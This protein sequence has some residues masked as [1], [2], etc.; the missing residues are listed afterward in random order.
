MID[1]L[2]Q[3]DGACEGSF[4]SAYFR[5]DENGDILNVYVKSPDLAECAEKC[6]EAFNNLTESEISEICKKIISCA[7]EGGMDEGFEL[8]AIDN[9]L[10][11]LNYCWFTALYVNMLSREDEIAYVI[12]GEG[13]WGDVIGFAVNNNEVV[14]VGTDYFDCMKDE[15]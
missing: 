9:D 10:D 12:E 14:Y 3:E 11:I 1:W 8:P 4:Q 6:V 5:D 15:E 2:H 13:D 7:K